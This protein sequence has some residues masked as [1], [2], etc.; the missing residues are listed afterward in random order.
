MLRKSASY[1][2]KDP[3]AYLSN[4]FILACD[5]S[6]FALDGIPSLLV[7]ITMLTKKTAFCWF[8]LTMLARQNLIVVASKLTIHPV[9]GAKP[10]ECY[11]LYRLVYS[12]IVYIYIY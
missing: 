9:D 10:P 11:M 3:H 4:I 1:V 6:S 7:H 12:S 2:D 5:T 8:K